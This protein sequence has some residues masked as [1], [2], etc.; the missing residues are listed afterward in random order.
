MET[1]WEV[2][3]FAW[4]L[5]ITLNRRRHP[6]WKMHNMHAPVRICIRG[7]LFLSFD[8]VFL[9]QRA[10]FSVECCM[11][12][13]R[14]SGELRAQPRRN[15]LLSL[16]EPKFHQRQSPPPLSAPPKI[17]SYRHLPSLLFPWLLLLLLSTT[18]CQGV[19]DPISLS[20]TAII[21]SRQIFLIY[22]IFILPL[23]FC[24]PSP[25][26]ASPRYRLNSQIQLRCASRLF[27]RY[28]PHHRQT[29]SP[30]QTSFRLPCHHNYYLPQ[31]QPS[32]LEHLQSML[33]WAQ[34][35][36]HG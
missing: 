26:C 25:S 5:H 34:R 32:H 2:V 3:L 6:P 29:S 28:R 31:R 11:I 19:S 8:T 23:F 7:S 17:A 18:T 36:N 10:Y 33:Y 27:L 4:L 21:D 14:R 24:F 9:Y 13:G 30:R 1:T 20:S 35:S 12:A 15:F 16:Q 22:F